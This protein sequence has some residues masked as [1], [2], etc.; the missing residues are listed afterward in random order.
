M[1]Y[2]T[3]H[4]HQTWR[5][6][7]NC[8]TRCCKMCCL[9]QAMETA[10]K[11]KC[12]RRAAPLKSHGQWVY[13]SDGSNLRSK[14][15]PLCALL[16]SEHQTLQLH[17]HGTLTCRIRLDWIR[18]DWKCHRR[19]WRWSICMWPWAIPWGAWH[20]QRHTSWWRHVVVTPASSPSSSRSRYTSA[21]TSWRR[22]VS[23]S[24]W[25]WKRSVPPHVDMLH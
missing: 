8:N 13:N 7:K 15:R 25:S 5:K 20:T 18:I 10:T 6:N 24:S 9:R 4:N 17:G 11:V 14:F 3:T 22:S 2:H 21:A 12:V 16:V 1:N 23:T 19:R